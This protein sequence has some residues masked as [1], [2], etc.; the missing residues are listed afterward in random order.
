VWCEPDEHREYAGSKGVA[1]HRERSTA[2]EE[3]SGERKRKGVISTSSEPWLVAAELSDALKPI[4]DTEKLST[5]DTTN[6]SGVIEIRHSPFSRGRNELENEFCFVPNRHS[7]G[8][9]QPK[10]RRPYS[11]GIE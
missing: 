1:T 6:T 4:E 9:W 11:I 2:G 3:H 8:N 5:M 7:L 10:T